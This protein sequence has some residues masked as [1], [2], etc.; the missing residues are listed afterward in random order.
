MLSL[1]IVFVH[2]KN[3]NIAGHDALRDYDYLR[4]QFLSA[5]NGWLGC[6]K[7][8]CDLRMCPSTKISVSVEEKHFK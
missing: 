4:L 6:P 3:Y 8:V 1:I 5:I 7:S 2:T